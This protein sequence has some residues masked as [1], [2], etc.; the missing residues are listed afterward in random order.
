MIGR[1]VSE[2]TGPARRSIDLSV[3]SSGWQAQ[4]VSAPTRQH[5][6]FEA[7]LSERI[8]LPLPQRIAWV[9]AS[10][11]E[12]RIFQLRDPQG[13]AAAQV[14]V[15]VDRLRR[16]SGL[17]VGVAARMGKATTPE[18]EE[19]GAGLLRTLGR[20]CG[21]L[22][23]LRLQAYRTDA[24]ALRDFEARTRR[25][26]F[27]LVDPIGPTR[28]LTVDLTQSMDDLLGWLSK[29]T[30]AR[31]RHRSDQVIIRPLDDPRHVP[32]CIEAANASLSRT[33]GGSTHFDFHAAFAMASLPQ[34]RAHFLG[35]FLAERPEQ[36][37]AFVSALHHG[38]LAEYTAAGSLDLAA[39]RAM[40]FYY[41]MLWDLMIWARSAGART[42]D[43]G[44]VTDGGAA[45]NCAGISQFKRHFSETDVELGREMSVTL[46]PVPA[47]AMRM[48]AKA[49]ES[50]HGEA[51]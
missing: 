28:T 2:L 27:E 8:E 6:A 11:L 16:V 40:P 12:H 3:Q 50:R 17:G 38:E 22:I 26:G 5:E 4:L 13:R 20:E 35:L 23:A 46:R 51:R 1:V 10:S 18:A 14:V 44:G 29:K 21:D 19:L 33:E 15:R 39:L 7:E 42:F 24:R 34:P 31:V 30:R 37:V 43:L 36:L 47:I 32:A 9:R 41:W 49:R 25:A 48:L 45:D